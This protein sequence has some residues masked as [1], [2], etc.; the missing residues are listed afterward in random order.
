MAWPA[1]PL[2]G[3][4]VCVLTSATFAGDITLALPDGSSRAGQVQAGDGALDPKGTYGASVDLKLAGQRGTDDPLL[5]RLRDWRLTAAREQSVPAYVIFRDATLEL[6]AER[7][8]ASLRELA[9]VPGVGRTKLDRYGAAV[10]ALCA[11]AA[12]RAAG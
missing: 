7:R 9:A 1:L 2:A 5:A 12:P 10:L 3:V 4:T 11:E 8:P 6:I